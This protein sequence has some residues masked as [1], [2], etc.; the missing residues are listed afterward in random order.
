MMQAWIQH[1]WHRIC[2]FFFFAV[3]MRFSS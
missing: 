2:I 3:K 1:T